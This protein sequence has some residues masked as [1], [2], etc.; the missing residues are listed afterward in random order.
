MVQL[1]LI[2]LRD[3]GFSERKKIF[4]TFVFKKKT[5]YASWRCFPYVIDVFRITDVLNKLERDLVVNMQYPI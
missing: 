2:S 1:L 4:D 3:F 5:F